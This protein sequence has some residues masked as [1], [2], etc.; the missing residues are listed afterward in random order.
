[1]ALFDVCMQ[2]AGSLMDCRWNKQQWRLGQLLFTRAH[3][4]SA[5]LQQDHT[6]HLHWMRSY[7]INDSASYELSNILLLQ[8]RTWITKNH[9][10]FQLSRLLH[11]ITMSSTTP[12][13]DYYSIVGVPSTASIAE[14]RTTIRKEIDFLLDSTTEDSVVF[15][16]CTRLRE[17]EEILCD[18]SLRAKYDAEY[19]ERMAS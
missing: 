18:E 14:I 3:C 6:D 19:Q 4:N 16:K 13:V 5:P 1:M 7:I 12:F 8:T 2:S 15:D 10:T 9:S 11:K 17:I